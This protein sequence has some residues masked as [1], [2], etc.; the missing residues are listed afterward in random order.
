MKIELERIDPSGNSTRYANGWLQVACMV[1]KHWWFDYAHVLGYSLKGQALCPQCAE[2]E[3]EPPKSDLRG[4]KLRGKEASVFGALD[5]TETEEQIASQ[6]GM[7]A[8]EV[9]RILQA[10]KSKKMVYRNMFGSWSKK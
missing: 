2:K 5:N 9:M 3:P 1:C 8:P 10:L 7:K 6:L 4:V